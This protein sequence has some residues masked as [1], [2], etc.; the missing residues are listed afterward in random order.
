MI[1][2]LG[3]K[4][5]DIRTKHLKKDFTRFHFTS[6]RKRMS[7]IIE[8]CGETQHDYDRRVHMKGASEYVLESCN[9]YLNQ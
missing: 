9:Y 2:K 7:T 1:I 5:E 8:N 6:K 4:F 3:I